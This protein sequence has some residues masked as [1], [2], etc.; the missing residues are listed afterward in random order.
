MVFDPLT[1]TKRFTEFIKMK[2]PTIPGPMRKDK[3]L[4]RSM[5]REQTVM[6]HSMITSHLA[7]L[8]FAS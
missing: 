2:S 7:P 1:E 3:A 5:D 4:R 6:S 8:L